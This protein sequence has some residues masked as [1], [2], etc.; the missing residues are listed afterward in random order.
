MSESTLIAGRGTAKITREDLRLLPVPL[1]T[2][3]HKPVPH[4]RIVEALIETL[5]FRHINVVADEYAVSPDGMKMFGLLELDYEFTGV[6]FAIGLRNSNDKSMRL[7]LTVGYR[8]M[9]CSNMAF[10]GDFT[11]VLAKHSKSF[12]LI[13]T[14]AI[15]VDRM[16][17]SFD[18]LKRNI[19]EWR[20]NQI[21]DDQAK[22][23]LYEAFV[24]GGLDV[25]PKMLPTVHHGYFHPELEA[26]QERTLWSLS[27]AFTDAFKDLK[28][29]QEFR[30]ASKLSPFLNRFNQPF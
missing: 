6:R 24:E 13:D 22:L 1:A 15:G 20:A 14:L 5:G 27:N 28:P 18:P 29:F 3:T 23:I 25:S 11:P 8:V 9:V 7:A 4:I 16:Q 10:Q 17:R 21:S 19:G 12:D 26:F 2:A 30:A